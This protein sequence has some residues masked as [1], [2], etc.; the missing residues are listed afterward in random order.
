MPFL[1]C[2]SAAALVVAAGFAVA[3]ADEKSKPDEKKVE[4]KAAAKTAVAAPAVRLGGAPANPADKFETTHKTVGAIDV[5]GSNNLRLQTLCLDSM[6]RVVGLVATPKPFGGPVKGA[7][8]EVHV[9]DAAGKPL[10]NFKVDFHGQAVNA[11]PDGSVFVAGDGKLARFDKSGKQI[12]T[13]TE[14]PFV[15]DLLKDTDGLKKKA[16]EQLKREKEQFAQSI[17]AA[18][19]QFADQ[20]KKLEDKKKEDRTKAEERQ[21]Q[22]AKQ[23]I[24][25][26]DQMEKEQKG[27]T[28]EQVLADMTGRVRVASGVAVSDK[29]VFVA[30]G[31]VGGYGYAVWRLSH[32][33]KDP[34]QVLSGIRGCCGQMDIQCH[35]PDVLVAE[36]TNKQFARYDREG[37][38]LGGYGKGGAETD[39]ACFGGCCNPMNVRAC[40]TGDVYTAESEGV[41]KRFSPSGEFLETTGVVKLSGGCKNVAV[42]V[43]P[44]A[45]KLYFLDQP[46]SKF[47]ILEKKTK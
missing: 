27:R 34:K 25:Q 22:Q 33:L 2:V 19:K 45:S 40:G 26:Y 46:G 36:N 8:A 17:G 6:G 10:H 7:T 38:K 39:P 3:T 16:E 23:L 1:R 21:L 30:C 29:D 31:D 11:G 14:L 41:I 37:K 44:D 35:G 24:E 20:I 43:S 42:G 18:K 47:H 9:F 13:S 12:G 32:D 5:K 15:A 4:A 28:V